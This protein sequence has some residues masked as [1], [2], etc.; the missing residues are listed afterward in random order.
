MAALQQAEKTI[1]NIFKDLP[2]L[3]KNSK[4]AL[5][6][7]WPWIALIFGVLQLAVAYWLWK[8][9]ETLEAI[10]NIANNISLVYTGTQIGLSSIDR[11]LIYLG[12][13]ILVVDAVILLMAYPHLKQRAK[14]GW[15]LVFLGTLIYM[16]YTVLALFI[17][18]RGIGDFIINMLG[19]AVSFYLLFQV[20]EFYKGSTSHTTTKV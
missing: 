8:S 14:R 2:S 20:R 5:V 16:L 17:E 6:N 18:G 15:E 9:I 4:E 11:T 7:S 13:A 1:G 3:P 12:V 19:A 10:T